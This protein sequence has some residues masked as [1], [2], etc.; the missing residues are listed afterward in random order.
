MLHISVGNYFLAAAQGFFRSLP[1]AIFLFSAIT[2]SQANILPVIVTNHTVTIAVA[3][4]CTPS[5]VVHYSHPDPCYIGRWWK[6]C[7][8]MRDISPSAIR[9]PLFGWWD[10][11]NI[12]CRLVRWT[13]F[14]KAKCHVW[15]HWQR[16]LWTSSITYKQCVSITFSSHSSNHN[17]TLLHQWIWHGNS[18]F[19][20]SW[21]PVKSCLQGYP[22]LL[23][24]F[25]L[26]KVLYLIK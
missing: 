13:H 25:A 22:S 15:I 16:Q 3:L 10:I 26:D 4:V 18:S 11:I 8:P 7:R 21:I 17:R 5:H 6:N 9:Y 19:S 2:N 20:K 14:L 12:S 23:L 1:S 24:W